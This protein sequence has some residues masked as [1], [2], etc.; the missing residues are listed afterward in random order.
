MSKLQHQRG[1]VTEDEDDSD[2]DDLDVEKEFGHWL[3][4][5]DSAAKVTMTI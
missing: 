2:V 1:A 4:Q 5:L 3:E